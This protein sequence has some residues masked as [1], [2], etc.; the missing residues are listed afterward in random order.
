MCSVS[1]EDEDAEEFSWDGDVQMQ[2]GGEFIPPPPPG[3]PPVDIVMMHQGRP[4][5]MSIDIQVELGPEEGAL[6]GA[7]AALPISTTR[8]GRAGYVT[9]PG[10]MYSDEEDEEDGSEEEDEEEDAHD[11]DAPGDAEISKVEDINAHIYDETDEDE[12]ETNE[13]EDE[14]GA[15]V[16]ESVE[17]ESESASEEVALKQK[18][19]A[20]DSL[21]QV[22]R[23][24]SE[25][26]SVS[27]IFSHKQTVASLTNEAEILQD[28][29][30]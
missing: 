10:Q 24:I 18:H 11:S 3:P 25:M 14:D 26:T 5:N 7:P 17:E 8:R 28:E 9:A 4:L 2:F 19:L 29:S 30:E 6:N 20:V 16:E 21:H 12:S 15:D 13:D 1:P 27:H 23:L 22:G